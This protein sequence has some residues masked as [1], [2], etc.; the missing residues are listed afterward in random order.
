[1][2]Q[3]RNNESLSYAYLSVKALETNKTFTLNNV[4]SEKKMYL[5]LGSPIPAQQTARVGVLQTAVINPEFRPEPLVMA[6]LV[7]GAALTST[8]AVL[9]S[10]K[11]FRK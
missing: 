4:P 3:I 7:G 2:A 6:S 1:M 8:S 10:R 11:R 5:L 9:S